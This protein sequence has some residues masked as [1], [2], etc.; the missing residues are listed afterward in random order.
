MNKTLT[1][2][3]DIYSKYG[4]NIDSRYGQNMDS[5]HGHYIAKQRHGQN[6]DI[7]DT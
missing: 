3:M 7:D 5:R 4:Q 2:D 6:I 1:V